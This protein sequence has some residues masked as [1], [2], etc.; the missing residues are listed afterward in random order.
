MAPP[1]AHA[2]RRVVLQAGRSKHCPMCRRP[3]SLGQDAARLHGTAVHVR[4]IRS[5]PR[6]DA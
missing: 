5:A 4:C 6:R 1:H 3:I 2:Q